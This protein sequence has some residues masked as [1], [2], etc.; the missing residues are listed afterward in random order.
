MSW[1]SGSA[2]RSNILLR[3]WY[4]PNALPFAFSAPP[5]RL[6]SSTKVTKDDVSPLTAQ[7]VGTNQV[8]VR[9]EPNRAGDQLVVLVSNYP[10]W[11]LYV[12]GQ[13]DT[14]RPVNDYLGAAMRPGEHTY[15]FVFRPTKHYVGLAVS[16]LTLAVMLGILL[17]ESPLWLHARNQEAS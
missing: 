16:V 5:S 9:G 10:G 1:A 6:R 8:A 14:L 17:V 12:D 2:A 13:P 7:L 4:L 15:T 11:R 3:L